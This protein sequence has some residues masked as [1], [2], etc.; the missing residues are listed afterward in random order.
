MATD[1]TA[2]ENTNPMR[3][4]HFVA[5]INYISI[6]DEIAK[7]VR[8]V[9]KMLQDASKKALIQEAGVQLAEGVPSCEIPSG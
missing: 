8:D 4:Y 9:P 1:K 3:I 6:V 2:N 5:S 7:Q